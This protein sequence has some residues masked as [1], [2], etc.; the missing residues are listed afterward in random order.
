MSG[1]KDTL[2]AEDVR[3]ARTIERLQKIIV[4]ELTKI[5]L[6]TY[7]AQG[8]EDADLINF[9]LELQNPSM[10]HEQE[11]LELMNQQIEAGEKAI[12]TKLFSSQWVYDNIFDFSDDEKDK[13]FK[14]L[15]DDA[16]R[17]NLDLN[18][19]IEEG[20]ILLKNQPQEPKVVRMMTISEQPRKGDWGGSE[21]SYF[22]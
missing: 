13:M 20:K 4:S 16:T 10:I 22:N 18:Q 17:T 6:F 8:F 9:D 1:G 5:V 19:L 15:I 3:F 11:K 12:E 7:I 2:V 14:D 21:K